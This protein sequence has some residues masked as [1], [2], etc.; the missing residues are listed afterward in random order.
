[1][2]YYLNGKLTYASPNMAVID[3]GGVGYK[4]TVSETTYRN[5][6]PRTL[7]T[8]PPT[9]KLY[10]YLSVKEDDMELFGFFEE[11]ELTSFKQLISVSGIGPKVA[12]SILSLLTPEKLALAIISEDRKAISSANGVG[13]KTAARVI[14]ELKDKMAKEVGS[15]ALSSAIVDTPKSTSAASRGKLTEATDALIVLGYGRA[16]AQNVLRS[17]DVEYLTLEEIIKTALKKLM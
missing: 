15:D 8:E 9:V 14:L 11:A 17:I 13:P 3:C 10:T 4:L 1:M 16:E 5:L 7:S 12:I 2:Y 6:P